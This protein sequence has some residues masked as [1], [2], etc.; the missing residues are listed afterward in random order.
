MINAPL[1]CEQIVSGSSRPVQRRE[2]R[3]LEYPVHIAVTRMGLVPDEL[4]VRTLTDA[5]VDAFA[6]ALAGSRIGRP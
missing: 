4:T 2:R 6:L 1:T 3:T 5:G